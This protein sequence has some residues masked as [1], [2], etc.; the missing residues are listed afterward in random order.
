M[1]G[2]SRRELGWLDCQEEG[3]EGLAGRG[4]GRA[5]PL[6]ACGPRSHPK[7]NAMGVMEVLRQGSSVPLPNAHCC[8]QRPMADRDCV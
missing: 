2:K 8:F 1:A 7:S 3:E 5:R 6:R 4:L